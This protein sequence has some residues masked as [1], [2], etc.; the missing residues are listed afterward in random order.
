MPTMGAPAPL[1]GLHGGAPHCG[2]A[3][4]APGAGAPKP[5]FK[6]HVAPLPTPQQP[7]GRRSPPW[8][9]CGAPAAV[10]AAAQGGAWA[11]AR[12][13][14]HPPRCPGPAWAKLILHVARTGQP[15]PQHWLGRSHGGPAL[16]AGPGQCRARAA[17]WGCQGLAA[18]GQRPGL[19]G[20]PN[21]RQKHPKS[22]PRMFC[23]FSWRN[24]PKRFWHPPNCFCGFRGCFATKLPKHF[25]SF[26][27]ESNVQ[28]WRCGCCA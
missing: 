16:A 15:W 14:P 9:G 13:A 2:G 23:R 19:A 1:Q 18:G 7:E 12:A 27:S 10:W 28:L 3:N 4:G 22:L 25:G 24:P 26:C 5:P 21:A 20:R 11:A 17:K 8:L 6:L